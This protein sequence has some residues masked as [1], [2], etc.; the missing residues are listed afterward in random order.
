MKRPYQDVL[1][2][3][4]NGYKIQIRKKSLYFVV[5]IGKV[6]MKNFQKKSSFR[7]LQWSGKSKKTSTANMFIKFYW[8]C[9]PGKSAE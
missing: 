4:E 5:K 1:I 8:L 3:K 7:K 9:K 6:D 2:T